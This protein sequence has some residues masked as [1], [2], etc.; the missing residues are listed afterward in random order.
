MKPMPYFVRL[1]LAST[2]RRLDAIGL[3]MANAG[4]IWTVDERSMYERRARELKRK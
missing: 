1:E 4:H 3:E 2:L